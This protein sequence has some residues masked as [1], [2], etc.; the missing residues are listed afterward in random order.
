MAFNQ[1]S[2]HEYPNLPPSSK[3]N[4]H[5]PLGDLSGSAID[6]AAFNL[7]THLPEGQMSDQRHRTLSLSQPQRNINQDQLIRTHGGQSAADPVSAS[8]G[9]YQPSPV[10]QG[11]LVLYKV[12]AYPDSSAIEQA[13]VPLTSPL[14]NQEQPA[15]LPTL[16]HFG[17]SGSSDR[18][19]TV[20]QDE[21]SSPADN[22]QYQP[23]EDPLLRSPFRK[24]QRSISSASSS[25]GSWE[26]PLLCRPPEKRSRT[27]GSPSYQPW[28][29]P[30][31][32]RIHRFVLD[33]HKW[34]GFARH[35]RR[36]R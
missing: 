20:A 24:R 5:L 8:T 33:K 19:A 3:A 1:A 34:A 35:G 4:K 17:K 32:H 22:P 18:Q 25:H 2:P 14:A 23:W 26:D 36:C 31:S 7:T 28:E 12:S 29:D 21:Q 10:K 9:L 11:Q 27:I 6:T 16:D 30:L 15:A 13:Q